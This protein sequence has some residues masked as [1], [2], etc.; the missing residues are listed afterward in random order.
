MADEQTPDP[1]AEGG[2]RPE[3]LLDRF[4]TTEAQAQAYAESQ[5]EMSRLRTQ[6][7]Q[8]R[9]SFASALEGFQTPQAPPPQPFGNGQPQ[10]YDPAMSAYA[11]AYENGDVQGM[12]N[13][14]AQFTLQPTI[15]AVGRLIDEKLSAITPAVQAAQ[16]AQREH[17][18][19]MAEGVVERQIGEERYKQVLPRVRELVAVHVIAVELDVRRGNHDR[20]DLAHR[21]HWQLD[22]EVLTSATVLRG[23]EVALAIHRREVV[24]RDFQRADGQRQAQK[25]LAELPGSAEHPFDECVV[26]R[27]DIAVAVGLGLEMRARLVDADRLL[28]RRLDR[29]RRHGWASL[30]SRPRLTAR[31]QASPL[32]GASSVSRLAIQNEPP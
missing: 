19:R 32:P 8:E 31:R 1:Q 12:L 16:V 5:A 4:Q 6:M 15:E 3:W 26:D 28:G 25:S 9:N 2:E 7:E 23:P 20:D 10:A 22:R 17:D 18:L 29:L 30:P 24:Q 11:V 21:P 27:I 13:A 14:Q